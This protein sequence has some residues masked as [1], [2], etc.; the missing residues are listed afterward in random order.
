MGIEKVTSVVYTKLIHNPVL[1][2]DS[3]NTWN[4]ILGGTLTLDVYERC[5]IDLYKITIS[6][7]LRDFQYRL[8]H[9]CIP[10]NKQLA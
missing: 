7:K 9:Y 1:M 3:Y 2:C 5:F 10:M 6:M 8:L 4:T